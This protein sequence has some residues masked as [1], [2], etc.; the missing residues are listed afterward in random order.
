MA[1]IKLR[2]IIENS[3]SQEQKELDDSYESN[4]LEVETA[5]NALATAKGTKEKVKKLQLALADGTEIH[6][7]YRDLLVRYAHE[8]SGWHMVMIFIQGVT[9]NETSF[10]FDHDEMVDNNLSDY[11]A[12]D[13]VRDPNGAYIE[14]VDKIDDL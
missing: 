8:G 13:L 2:G 12:L 1:V 6:N 11:V 14:F 4:S 9:A 5:V 3:E 10:E 7:F